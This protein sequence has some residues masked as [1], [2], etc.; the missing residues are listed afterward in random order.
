[1][2]LTKIQYTPEE[3]QKKREE[4]ER[5]VSTLF[6]ENVKLFLKQL[7]QGKERGDMTKKSKNTN[8]NDTTKARRGEIE[9][10]HDFTFSLIG[11]T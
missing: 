8:L 9:P 6:F 4:A 2:G 5:K 7:N 10:T 3:L 11:K 1:M